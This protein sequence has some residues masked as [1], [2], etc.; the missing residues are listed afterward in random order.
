[1]EGWTEREIGY[2]CHSACKVEKCLKEFYIR[3]PRKIR[4]LK[5]N[6]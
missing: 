2:I 6:S 3:Y 1:M 4:R 5:T